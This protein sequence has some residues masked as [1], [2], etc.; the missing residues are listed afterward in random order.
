MNID[1]N[2]VDDCIGNDGGDTKEKSKWIIRMELDKEAMLDKHVTMDDINFAI[3][4]AYDEEVH[5]VYS[6]YNSDKLIFRL[7]LANVLSNKKKNS[8]SN[9]LDQSD[10]IYLLKNFQDNLLN[11]IVLSGVKNIS[12]VILR[13]VT[14]NV[15]K[16]HGKYSKQES[17]VLDTVGS[18]LLEV[19]ALDYID[20]NRTVSNDIQEIYRTFGIEAAR[21]AIFNELTEVIE[22]DGT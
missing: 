20:V 17:W 4:N 11:N 18:N 14:D 7:R 22:F 12:K 8:K 1:E 21:N 5:C 16:D 2:I 13:K 6:D 3:S 9:P 15:V 10:E 19:L